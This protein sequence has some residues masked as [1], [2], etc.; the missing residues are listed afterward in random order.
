[1]Q[2]IITQRTPI[3][4]FHEILPSINDIFIRLVEGTPTTRQFQPIS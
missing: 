1:L 3:V 4:E 2:A